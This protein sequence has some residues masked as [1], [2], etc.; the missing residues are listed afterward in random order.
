MCNP[1]LDVEGDYDSGLWSVFLCSNILILLNILMCR[2]RVLLKKS[3]M[4]LDLVPPPSRVHN[5][6]FGRT[7]VD[8]PGDMVMTN[9]T[10]GDK[11]VLYF[12]PCNWFG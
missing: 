10:T 3:N 7:W 6:I 11:V 4:I 2:T 5:L 8:S 9:L 1:L 12:H